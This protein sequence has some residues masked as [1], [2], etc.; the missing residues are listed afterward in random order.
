MT[1]ELIFF[2]SEIITDDE[3]DAPV[4][5]LADTPN[6]RKRKSKQMSSDT[7]NSKDATVVS[8][9]EKHPSPQIEVSRAKGKAASETLN[10]GNEPEQETAL[11]K[12]TKDVSENKGS[13]NIENVTS[14]NAHINS[15]SNRINKNSEEKSP[16]KR[17]NK[18]KSAHIAINENVSSIQETTHIR[19]SIKKL[20]K[21]NSVK[22]VLSKT[23][24]TISASS[25]SPQAIRVSKP[26]PKTNDPWASADVSKSSG[27]KGKSQN[28]VDKTKEFEKPKNKKAEDGSK[29]GTK[30][31]SSATSKKNTLTENKNA[32]SAETAKT[33]KK[34]T[35]NYRGEIKNTHPYTEVKNM[36]KEAT[37]TAKVKSS[38][39]KETVVAKETKPATKAK[40]SE[41]KENVVAKAAT[42]PATKA[43]ASDEVK[44]KT[45]KEAPK[46][47][48][49][50][51]EDEAVGNHGKFVI[52]RTGADNF[53]FKLFSSNK[54]VV[55]VS[56]GQYTSLGACKNGVQ[57]VMNNAATAPIEDQTLKNVVE[58]KFP[59]WVV[60]LD[61]RGEFRLRLYA[62]NGN[63][64]AATNDGYLS[65]DAAKKGIDAIARAAKDAEVERNDDLW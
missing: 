23:D 43:N 65:K 36:A 48:V 8:D 38:T 56:A 15:D 55:A 29:T 46:A 21:Q 24:F 18:P 10:G 41:A 12:D 51:V 11:S 44:E 37:K 40:N 54:R 57:S 39:E 19:T 9:A 6:N 13:E 30:Q 1:D 64:V 20:D 50:A 61:K 60:Y 53:V 58:Q 2:E 49:Q 63:M 35:D 28:P 27:K 25:E 3:T 17:E 22:N 5:T 47:E 16:Q 14:K 32:A 42:K 59:K 33:N 45:A 7:L 34:A 26:K 4:G 31:D 52:K 62:S